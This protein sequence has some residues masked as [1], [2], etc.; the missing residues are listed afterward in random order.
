MAIFFI[1]RADFYSFFLSL[2]GHSNNVHCLAI[3]V[4]AIAGAVFGLYGV[5][6]QKDRMKDFIIVTP[7]SLSLS[8]SSSSYHLIL[9]SRY[10]FFI[11]SQF[12]SSRI[13]TLAKEA[14]REKDAPKA[15][16]AIYVLLDLVS[17]LVLLMH[18]YLSCFSSL[19]CTGVSIPHS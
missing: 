13:M 6:E 1:L 2:L 7:L 11:P 16:E 3:A 5:Q 8:L 10:V 14:D 4:N 18:F 9:V 17:N 15:R 19:V 12:T